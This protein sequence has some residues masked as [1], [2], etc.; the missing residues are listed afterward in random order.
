MEC[1]PAEPGARGVSISSR[2]FSKEC[3]PEGHHPE[4]RLP[5]T[6]RLH[7]SGGPRSPR[8]GPSGGWSPVAAGNLEQLHRPRLVAQRSTVAQGPRRS[9]GDSGGRSRDQGAPGN[10]RCGGSGLGPADHTQCP[11]TELLLRSHRQDNTPRRVGGRRLAK[12]RPRSVD[13]PG[14]NRPR[15]RAG[16]V[17]K[18]AG[19][20]G[21]RGHKH[22]GLRN[23]RVP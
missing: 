14:A 17:W 15:G 13:G 10:C 23:R 18:R 9:G 7:H 11:G 5:E 1:E 21:Q 2:S 8:P 12:H 4:D 20:E 16:Q 3:G 19:L 22:A 6:R